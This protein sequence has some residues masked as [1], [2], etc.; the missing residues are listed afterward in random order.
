MPPR[1]APRST[2]RTKTAGRS[3]RRTQKPLGNEGLLACF[4]Q[5]DGWYNAT[6]SEVLVPEPSLEASRRWWDYFGTNW[7]ALLRDHSGEWVAIGDEGLVASAADLDD[8]LS[9]LHEL[10]LS[11][12][13]DVMVRCVLPYLDRLIL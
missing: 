4:G 5:I 10:R 2:T 7:P 1:T 13:R 9:L 8:L 11:P 3:S 6:M 12:R